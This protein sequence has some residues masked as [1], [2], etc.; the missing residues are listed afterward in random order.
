MCTSIDGVPIFNHDTP[1]DQPFCQLTTVVPN[2]GNDVLIEGE[3]YLVKVACV[4]SSGMSEWSAPVEWVYEPCEHWGPVDEVEVTTGTEGNHIEWVFDHSYNPYSL[5]LRSNSNQSNETN[6]ANFLTKYANAPVYRQYANDG[7]LLNF[8]GISDIYFRTYLLYTLYKDGQ[9]TLVPDNEYGQFIVTPAHEMSNFMEAFELTY[10]D[11][12]TDYS[13]MSKREIDDHMAEWKSGAPSQ[14]GMSITMDLILS[15]TRVDNDHCINS[16]PFCTTEVLSFAASTGSEYVDEVGW[17]TS[18][19][20]STT[21]APRPAWYHMRIR[22]AGPF[23][24]HMEG[25]NPNYNPGET[26]YDDAD[27]DFCIWGPYTEEEMTSGYACTH[28][29]GDK[30]IDCSWSPDEIEDAYLGYPLSEHHHA[31]LADNYTGSGTITYHVPEVGEYYILMI[32]N[33][34]STPCEISFT[35]TE[36]VGET[37]CEL[38][39]PSDALGFLITMDGEF[40]TF[41]MNPNLREYTHVGE[42]GDHEYCVR[43]IYPGLQELPEHNYYFSM[44]CPVCQNTGG[45]LTC[46][47]GDPIHVEELGATDQVKIW[48]GEET[49]GPGPGGDADTFTVD[50][51]GGMPAGWTTIDSDGDGYGWVLGSACNGIYL[52]GGNLSGTGHNSSTD[53]MTS[54]SYSNVVGPLTPDNYLVSPQV[55][56]AAGS[57]FSFWACAQDANYA[58]ERFGVFVS[59]NGTSDWTSVQEWTM[60]A[61][62]GSGVMSY[63]RGGNTRAQGTWHQYTVDLSAYAGD[64]YIAIRHFDCTDMFL[65]N[66]DDIE[67]S[68]GAKSNRATIEQYNVYRADEAEGT[69][70]L[71]GEVPYVAEQTYYEYIDTPEAAGTYYYKVTAL[72][73]N[74]CESEGAPSFAD[75]TVNFVVA[76]VTGMGENNDKVVLYPNPTKGN[77]TIEANGMSR[78]SVVSVLGQVVY[79]T[80]VNASS[81]TLN[82]SQFNAGM[83]M[84]RVYTENG[85][86]IKR[87]TVMQ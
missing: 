3:H 22:E 84:V 35:K 36:G 81:Y 24:I 51:D 75:P 11:A 40:L 58:A 8:L 37:D 12:A 74:S 82:M 43:P 21:S 27:I 13:L 86:T 6:G 77:V 17:E 20:S 47:P 33:Y 41:V 18:C 44:G 42:F 78:I 83:Y 10:K 54:G 29:N 1:A 55:T 60:T 50:F 19:Y 2:T 4:Y 28:L 85:V 65:L 68:A 49:P 61:K 48:W 45:E 56:L 72:Y 52:D 71:I 32:T 30:I 7:L 69:Y 70:V 67:L 53:L 26:G 5:D 66:V 46:A 79:D 16:L 15:N 80:E 63:G 14:F 39:A 57:T 38:V 76:E 62:G 9:F 23:V 25:H 34:R 59:D 64:K 87:V 73:S 31:S